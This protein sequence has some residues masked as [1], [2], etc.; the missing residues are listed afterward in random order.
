MRAA[1]SPQARL[2]DAGQLLRIRRGA[3]RQCFAQPRRERRCVLRR[4]AAP[5]HNLP[6]PNS[7]VT[8]GSSFTCR[9]TVDTILMTCMMHIYQSASNAASELL[10]SLK[11]HCSGPW[12]KTRGQYLIYG[13]WGTKHIKTGTWC[14]DSRH[15]AYDL[16]MMHVYQ[17]ASN[18]ASELLTSLKR[19]CPRP[20]LKRH[21][22]RP[23]LKTRGQ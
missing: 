23:W 10:I 22:P 13:P 3:A 18:A 21:C 1:G 17:S 7:P 14:N 2:G 12:L 20:W 6:A 9:P 5:A 15:N 8:R 19:H 11:R 4:E 16:S